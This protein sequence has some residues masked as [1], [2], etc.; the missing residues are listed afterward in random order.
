MLVA[1]LLLTV[2]SCKMP[3]AQLEWWNY[4]AGDEH[5]GN[6]RFGPQLYAV[7]LQEIAERHRTPDCAGSVMVLLSPSIERRKE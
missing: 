3:H 7:G 5:Q 4:S 6:E 1:P 2:A